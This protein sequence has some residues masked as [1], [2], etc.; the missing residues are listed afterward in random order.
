MTKTVLILGASGKV[1]AHCKTAFEAAGWQVRTFNRKTDD[2]TQSAIG[3]DVIVNGMNPPNYHDWAGI[4]PQI[5]RDVI[6]AARASGA[7]VILPGNVY[8]FGNRPGDWSE[9]T[10]HAPCSSKGHIR[11]EIERMYRDSGVQTINLRAG[12]FIDPDRNGDVFS[13]MIAGGLAKGKMGLPAAPEVT[14]VWAFMPDLARA[15]EVLADKRETLGQYEDVH[16]PGYAMSYADIRA[17]LETC[18]GTSLRYGRFPWWAMRLASPV[19]ELARELLEMR[20]LWDTPH[21]LTS[22][23]YARLL[24]GFKVTPFQE[25]LRQ[26]LPKEVLPRA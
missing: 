16:F 7:T 8:V 25:V 23:K 9:E 22:D 11:A 5:T 15:M 13:I 26:S 18:L 21:R 6:A 17:E 20:Y 4:L 10:P 19:W 24:P 1:G 12:N 2:M 3:A 14:Q